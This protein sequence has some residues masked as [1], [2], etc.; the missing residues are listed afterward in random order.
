MAKNHIFP[1]PSVKKGNGLTEVTPFPVTMHYL[2]GK[3]FLSPKILSEFLGVAQE[4]IDPRRVPRRRGMHR[5]VPTV[6]E[7]VHFQVDLA[8]RV[9]RIS[10]G[11]RRQEV[12][13]RLERMFI[14]RRLNAVR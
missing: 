9:G 8:P 4:I 3:V 6:E 12:G 7:I 11:Q 2:Y 5:I 13:L 1:K 14:G 10:D